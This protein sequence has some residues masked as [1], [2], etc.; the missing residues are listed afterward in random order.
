VKAAHYA[1]ALVIDPEALVPATA[2][3]AAAEVLARKPAQGLAGPQHKEEFAANGLRGALGAWRYL[4]R[5]PEQA[6]GTGAKPSHTG[7]K[8]VLGHIE[9]SLDQPFPVRLELPSCILELGPAGGVAATTA[10]SGGR[11]RFKAHV[12]R[13]LQMRCGR[14]QQRR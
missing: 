10:G 13:N 5:R 12:Q 8:N 3:L 1:V 9:C 7:L 6:L 11:R 14:R 2:A 4:L